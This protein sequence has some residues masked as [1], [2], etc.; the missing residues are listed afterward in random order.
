LPYWPIQYG[1]DG[2][3]PLTLLAFALEWAASPARPMLFHAVTIALYALT[4]VAVWWLASSII[5]NRHAWLVAALFAVHPV[6]VE[7][8]ANIVGQAEVWTSLLLVVSTAAYIRLRRTETLTIAWKLAIGLAYFAA[9]LFKEHAV[10]LP[11]LLF[12]AEALLIDGAGRL[13]ARLRQLRPFFL[14]LVAV[15]FFY[16]ALHELVIGKRFGGFAPFVPFVSL[17]VG[18]AD[19]VLT[20]VGMVPEWVRLLIWPARLSP[21]YGPPQFQIAHGLSILQLP[22]FLILTGVVGLALATARRA[23]AVS[24]GIVW[25]IVTLLP[26]SNFVLPSGILIAERTLFTPSFGALLAIGATLAAIS[27][28]LDTLSF[29][30][31][32]LIALPALLWLGVAK[33]IIGTAAWRDND[34]L[35]ANAV[36]TAPL[37]YRPHYL[38]GAWL[39]TKG[40][41]A[42]G[43]RE[44]LRAI[45]LF[46]FDP[47]VSYS[48]ARGYFDA[49]LYNRAYAMFARA[50]QTMPGFQDARGQMALTR[51]MQGRYAE[52]KALAGRALRQ[53]GGGDPATMTSIILAASL[54]SVSRKRAASKLAASVPTMVAR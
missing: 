11:I 9:C 16:V 48:L 18:Y 50:D 47:F 6:H 22:G 39:M 28:K 44:Y 30:R 10:V 1:G 13:S 38:L 24:F 36:R 2:Y 54:D 42:A 17:H 29:R 15:G 8:V 46:P 34:T 35:F 4:S 45:A 33:S 41:F 49:G 40:N 53:G 51:A 23:P 3:R 19:R 7:A 14:G 25:L 52:A 12:A 32:A 26:S 37:E 5:P 27:R 31:A 43:E 21:A 20:M